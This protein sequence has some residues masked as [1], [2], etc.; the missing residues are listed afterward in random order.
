MVGD[1]ITAASVDQL[2]SAFVAVGVASPRI[3]GVRSRRIEV[4]N[5]KDAPLSGLKTIYGLLGE[6]LRPDAWVIEL[7]TNDV[8]SYNS[9]ADYRHL[10]DEVLTML[11]GDAAV[12]WVNTFRP[13]YMQ[14]TKVFNLVLQ[15]RLQQRGHTQ[16]VDWY[17]AVSPKNSRLLIADRVHPNETGQRVLALLVAQALQRL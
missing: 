17:T 16:L 14:D 5:G 3:D 6:G 2:N 9:D 10:I 13:Q 15:D 7:G 11:P 4:G 8:G 12:V 1:S